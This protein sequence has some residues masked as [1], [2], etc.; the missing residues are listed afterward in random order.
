MSRA[1]R[2]KTVLRPW[3]KNNLMMKNTK[4]DGGLY[5]QAN[6]DTLS[7]EVSEWVFAEGRKT[8]D[9]TM[10]VAES[11]AC[12]IV[13]IMGP[14]QVYWKLQVKSAMQ[15]AEYE[16]WYENAKRST[17]WSAMRAV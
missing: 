3:Q 13:Y 15:T 11:G 4:E 14:D 12:Y 1:T 10:V 17:L 8:G 5:Q 9:A 6:K 2:Q 16:K 7:A